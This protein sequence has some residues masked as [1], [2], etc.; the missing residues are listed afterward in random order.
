M[1]EKKKK[2]STTHAYANFIL[3]KDHCKTPLPLP[4]KLETLHASPLI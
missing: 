4:C 3:E 2:S 1:I